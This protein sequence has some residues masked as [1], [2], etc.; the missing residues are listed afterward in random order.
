MASV[1][2]SFLQAVFFFIEL[3]IYKC[4]CNALSSDC[5]SDDQK[6]NNKDLFVGNK[7]KGRI[8]K[9]VFQESKTRTCAYQEVR[10]VCFSEVLACFAFLKH[11][12]EIRPFALL[13]TCYGTIS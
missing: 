8:S 7:A 4:I 11:R 6:S 1:F 2:V 12:F 3:T 13:P 10:N 5:P 9:R